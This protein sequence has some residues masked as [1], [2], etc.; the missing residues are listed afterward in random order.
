MTEKAPTPWMLI[1][2]KA[3]LVALVS[4]ALGVWFPP[5]LL[6]FCVGLFIVG[7]LAGAWGERQG[8]MSGI[9]VGVIVPLPVIARWAGADAWTSDF[10]WLGGSAAFVS[11]GTAIA[12]AI[13]GAWLR[14][15]RYA[16]S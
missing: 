15:K 1:F 9:V 5:S 3:L 2:W 12:G 6:V 13:T 16:A 11:S 7:A 14:H 4:T 8:W 10:W